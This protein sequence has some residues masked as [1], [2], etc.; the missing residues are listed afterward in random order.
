MSEQVFCLRLYH[1]GCNDIVRCLFFGIVRYQPL[2]TSSTVYTICIHNCSLSGLTTL[3]HDCYPP[4]HDME[5]LL[6]LFSF[7][8]L[9]EGLLANLRQTQLC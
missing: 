1:W 6:A 8:V 7:G 5:G 2:L 4:C 3:P 9:Q